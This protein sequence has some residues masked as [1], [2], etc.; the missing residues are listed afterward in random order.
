MV[1]SVQNLATTVLV[2]DVIETCMI[3]GLMIKSTTKETEHDYIHAPISPF[4]TPFPNN[5]YKEA[6]DL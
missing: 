6:I 3:K 1:E 4:P 2:R 5:L